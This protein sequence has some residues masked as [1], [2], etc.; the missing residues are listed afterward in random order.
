MFACSSRAD[1]RAE[2]KNA[3]DGHSRA[4][5][6][7]LTSSATPGHISAVER[8]REIRLDH[9][10]DH[11]RDETGTDGDLLPQD[12][13]RSIVTTP[14]SAT[15]L[16][17][18][19]IVA[20]FLDRLSSS[21]FR[22]RI[23]VDHHTTGSGVSVNMAHSGEYRHCAGDNYLTPFTRHIWDFERVFVHSAFGRSVEGP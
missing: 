20:G 19:Y 17:L 12:E 8:D 13:S 16:L 6:R 4:R 21:A 15:T 5:S 2:G 1:T 14:I 9:Q 7:R 18:E 10:H 22:R 11:T 3:S 23:P